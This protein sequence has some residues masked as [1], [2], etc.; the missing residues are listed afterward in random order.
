M[1]L[2]D[3]CRD[4]LVVRPD[5]AWDS[6]LVTAADSCGAIGDKPGDAL[7]VPPELA[8]ELTA[9]VALLEVLC[10]GASP[11][12][13]ALNVCN[14]PETAERLL[15][16]FRRAAPSL[17]AVMSTEKNMPTSMSAFGVSVTGV[18]RP[19]ALR[20]GR[21]EAG[22]RLFCAGLP[23]CGGEVLAHS[24]ALFS[25]SH[26]V[27]LF[28]DSRVHAA[29][30]CG[31]GGILKEAQIIAAENG[32]SAVIEAPPRLDLEKSAGPAS[33]AIFAASVPA[34]HGFGLDIPVACIGQL[35]PRS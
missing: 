13:A 35:V 19:E 31:S 18:C 5:D 30:P 15:A 20:L 11:A 3:T 14:E 6:W 9:R 24:G 27:T 12:F 23:L 4:V 17:P 1:P 33:C 29:I 25:P 7:H 16:G 32:L 2:Y 22:D 21:A 8:A 26:L 34:G 28:A 10:T